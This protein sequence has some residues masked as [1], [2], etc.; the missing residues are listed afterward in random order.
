VNKLYN[1]GGCM[2]TFLEWQRW[3]L[4]WGYGPGTPSPALNFVEIAQGDLSLRE[5][6]NQKLD[7]FA[8]FSYLSPY[9]YTD[10]LKILLKRTE[11]LGIHQQH[12][13]SSESLKGLAGI[14]LP[15]RW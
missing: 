6:F 8:I 14:A 13:I 9:F 7:I 2:P 11:D 3:N 1:V 15:H 5:N 12:K 4:A 10:N